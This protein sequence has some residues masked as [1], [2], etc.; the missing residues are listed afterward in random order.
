MRKICISV[1]ISTTVKLSARSKFVFA[2]LICCLENVRFYFLNM[3]LSVY[4]QSVLYFCT[5][6]HVLKTYLK[7]WLN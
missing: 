5:V 7:K 2:H 6:T 3:Q 4:E 1:I